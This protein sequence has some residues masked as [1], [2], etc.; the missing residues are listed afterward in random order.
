MSSTCQANKCPKK[1]VIGNWKLNLVDGQKSKELLN[2]IEKEI[3][4]ID[5]LEHVMIGVVVMDIHIWDI[6]ESIS[7]SK[8]SV[9]IGSQ[10][11]LVHQPGFAY[12]C[13]FRQGRSEYFF[14]NN[15]R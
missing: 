2:E 8:I 11:F 3:V 5:D 14:Y 6:R 15:T 10:S 13:V 7:K 9:E 4:N 12:F 1:I